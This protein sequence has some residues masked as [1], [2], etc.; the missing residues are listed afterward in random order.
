M[1]CSSKFGLDGFSKALS[2]E[3]SQHGIKITNLYPTWIKTNISTNAMTGSGEKFGKVDPNNKNAI[4]IETAIDV[5]VKSIY[6]RQSSCHL[7]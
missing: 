3:L 4:P 6:L 7:G 1:Y 2:P 5:F